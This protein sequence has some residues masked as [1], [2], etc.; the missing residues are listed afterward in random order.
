MRNLRGPLSEDV[1]A[2]QT[3]FESRW[4]VRFLPSQLRMRSHLM[5]TQEA[6]RTFR[7]VSGLAIPQRV[8]AAETGLA[9]SRFL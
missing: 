8:T 7:E 2:T 6:L 5:L 1:I 3:R 9:S 4:R